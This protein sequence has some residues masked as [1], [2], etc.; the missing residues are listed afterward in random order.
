MNL[1]RRQDSTGIRPSIFD[2]RFSEIEI[3][4]NRKSIDFRFSKMSSHHV[5]PGQPV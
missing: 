3:D 4:E 2:F 5:L 1:G